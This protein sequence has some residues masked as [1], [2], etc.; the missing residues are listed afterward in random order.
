MIY[1]LLLISWLIAFGAYAQV[2][3][4]I[5]DRN[6]TKNDT[7]NFFLTVINGLE[8]EVENGEIINRKGKL[9]KYGWDCYYI[10]V[11]KTKK[12]TVNGAPMMTRDRDIFIAV[13]APVKKIKEMPSPFKSRALFLKG[14]VDN[15]DS[16][17]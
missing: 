14:M 10:H 13:A 12:L 9:V 5:D 7:I 16:L 3:D 8:V 15:T 6:L 4:T 17:T 11:L 2:I 1:R